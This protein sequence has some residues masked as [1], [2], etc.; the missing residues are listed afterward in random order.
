MRMKL[1]VTIVLLA[2]VWLAAPVLAHEM[3]IQG[4]VAAIEKT[5]IQVK[6]GKEK[7]GEG[8]TWYPI[9]SRTKIKRGKSTIAADKAAIAVNE[10][11][12]LIVDHTEKGP[13]ILKEIR[14]ADK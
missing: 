12:V 4:T 8:P 2:A 14:L 11:V 9:G 5:R 6:T 7:T 1:T 13:V 10:R 3:T